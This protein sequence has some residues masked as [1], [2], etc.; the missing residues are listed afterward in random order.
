MA[1]RT[2]SLSS[3]EHERA[4]RQFFAERARSVDEGGVG[5]ADSLESLTLEADLAL[6]QDQADAFTEFLAMTS[7]PAALAEPLSLAFPKQK[8]FILDHGRLKALFCT[9]RAA[10]SYTGGL[11]IFHEALANPGCNLLFVGLTRMSAKGIVWKDVFKDLDRRLGTNCKFNESELTVT[12]PNGSIVYVTGIDADEDEMMKL[13]GKKYRLVI[14]DEGSMYSV[15]LNTFVYG[16]MKPTLADQ[17][18]TLC[19]MGT[20]SN[21]TR[22]LFFDVTRGIEPGWKLHTW[23]AYDNPHMEDAWAWEIAEIEHDRPLFMATALFRQWYLN[24]WVIDETALVYKYNPARNDCR[25]LPKLSKA[26]WQYVLG[27][28][29]GF[30]DENAFSVLAFHEEL[31][32]LFVV[33]VLKKSG[34]DFTDTA[35]E[36]KRLD[37]KYSFN[38]KVV[39]GANKQGVAEMNKRHGIGL[40][41]AE[42]QDKV[43][44]IRLLNDDL[45]QEALVLLPEA[46]PLKAEMAELVWCTDIAGKILEPRKENPNLPNH[47]CDATLY[48]WRKCYQ[49]LSERPK[50]PTKP[51]TP[52]WAREEEERM[53]QHELEIGEREREEWGGGEGWEG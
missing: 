22:G 1:T 39:D 42:K 30:N 18:G 40:V 10:K 29:L 53:F 50:P 44:F 41:R 19:M 23:A 36:V 49:Y 15:D 16:V 37:K 45:V 38:F 13:L 33:E 48:A 26:G 32:R 28:D 25:E 20:A 5:V 6:P 3:P 46:Q 34:M 35:N 12:F 51:G 52:E 27:L 8:A 4:V 2:E 24:E 9:R 7:A 17:S 14:L 43:D 11:Y 21:T 31:P 47:G